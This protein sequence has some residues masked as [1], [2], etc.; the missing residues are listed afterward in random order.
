[1]EKEPSIIPFDILAVCVYTVDVM[2]VI[3]VRDDAV[4]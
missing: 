3:L 2:Y 4:E 1:M